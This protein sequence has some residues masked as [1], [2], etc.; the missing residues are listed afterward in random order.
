MSAAVAAR[1]VAP[2]AAVAPAGGVACDVFLHVFGDGGAGE[3]AGEVYD[4]QTARLA[5]MIDPRFL[6]EC[7]WDPAG[8]VLAPRADHPQLRSDR[9]GPAP[10]VAAGAAGCAVSGCAR[11]AGSHGSD[12]SCG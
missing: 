5:R 8:R 9:V 10:V 4:E 2:V 3:V 11:P 1:T 7:G 12:R 6:G